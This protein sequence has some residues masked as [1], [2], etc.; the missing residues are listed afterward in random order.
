M[1]NEYLNQV[2]I[3]GETLINFK[4]WLLRHESDILHDINDFGDLWH[5]FSYI[6]GRLTDRNNQ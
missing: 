4:D 1:T 2:T 3:Q 5:V 6:V